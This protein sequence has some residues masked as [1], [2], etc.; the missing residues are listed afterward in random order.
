VV[1]LAQPWRAPLTVPIWYRYTPGGKLA[2]MTGRDSRK[3]RLL[4]VGTPVALCAQTEQAPYK[5]VSLEGVVTAIDAVDVE[6]DTRLWRT[7]TSGR[8]SAISTCS[9]WPTR[10]TRASSS[11]SA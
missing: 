11:T 7:G 9:P 1:S 6:R 2:F 4:A 3:G 10:R 5:Y 8:G